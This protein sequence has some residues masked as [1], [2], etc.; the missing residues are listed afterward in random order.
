MNKNILFLIF[1]Y[2]FL[3]K[4][5]TNLIENGDFEK[6]QNRRFTNWYF[7]GTLSLD[8]SSDAHQGN[9]AAQIY[10]NGGSFRITKNAEYNVIDVEEG[11]EYTFSYW[12][13]AGNSSANVQPIFT[14]YKGNSRIRDERL[15]T[16]NSTL[17]WR[18]HT[19]S[20][21][22]PADADKVG[23]AFYIPSQSG[24]IVLF[25]DIS[26]VFKRGATTE[27]APPTGITYKN[28]QREI[29]LSWN[30]SIQKGIQ[31]EIVVNNQN[32][33]KTSENSYILENLEPNTNYSIKIRATKGGNYS[34]YSSVIRLNTQRL[35]TNVEDE[36]RIPYLR[37]L[38][39]EAEADSTILLYYNDLA[40]KNAE[41]TYFIDNVKTLPVGN[42]LTFP[43]K[44]NQIL[45]II[46]KETDDREWELEYKMTIK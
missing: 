34:D 11:A 28:Y 33:I 39:S 16:I 26:F 27:L 17:Q 5:Q 15:N 6:Y 22:I 32:P 40:E 4:A 41:I 38:N 10:A 23:I 9:N 37:T 1:F 2:P 24:Q 35:S 20:I 44:G 46:I 13:K 29:E 30:K 3:L 21:T 18:E 19:Q 43:K 14:W 8:K 31:W 25:D 42:T 7:D 45:K 36:N 12:V